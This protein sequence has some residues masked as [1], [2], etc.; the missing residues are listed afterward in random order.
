MEISLSALIIDMFEIVRILYMFFIQ[1]LWEKAFCND[2]SM[3]QCILT[4]MMYRFQKINI[5]LL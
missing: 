2:S 4:F 5:L 1:Y 3:N